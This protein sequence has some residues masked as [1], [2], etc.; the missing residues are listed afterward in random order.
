MLIYKTCGEEM[1]LKDD[2]IDKYVEG[3]LQAGDIAIPETKIN[4]EFLKKHGYI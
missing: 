1:N 3:F 4:L 2:S